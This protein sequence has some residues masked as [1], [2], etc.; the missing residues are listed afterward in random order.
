MKSFKQFKTLFEESTEQ[1][2]EKL[3]QFAIENGFG[4]NLSIMLER[5]QFLYR[6]STTMYDA[7]HGSGNMY[8]VNKMRSSQ[9][10]SI[11]S[12]SKILTNLWHAHDD[13]P[14]RK[15]ARFSTT[16]AMAAEDFGK[17]V[18]IV[19][20]DGSAITMSP[21]DF[22]V[23]SR[24]E[25]KKYFDT[26]DNFGFSLGDVSAL[27]EELIQSVVNVLENNGDS[28]N[29]DLLFNSFLSIK[30]TNKDVNEVKE[31]FAL[32][33]KM[34]KRVKSFIAK[35]DETSQQSATVSKI[36]TTTSSFIKDGGFRHSMG[37]FNKLAE[38]GNSFNY[39]KSFFDEVNGNLITTT[40]LD[41]ILYE[42]AERKDSIPEIWWEGDSLVIVEMIRKPIYKK[43]LIKALDA[44][45][46]MNHINKK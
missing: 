10:A 26:E 37:L 46:F 27:I 14:S 22:N 20:K 24:K 36:K 2:I 38:H 19:P 35:R 8:I 5:S 1:S 40:N 4:E 18:I 9:R 28:S 29:A 21:E 16:S 42:A 32:L 15:V 7:V 6:G 45:R 39:I 34:I 25:I 11:Y 3:A 17:L 31:F 13:L 41:D 30:K 33:D 44:A 23:G 43:M 12:S